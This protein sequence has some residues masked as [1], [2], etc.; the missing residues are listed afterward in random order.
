MRTLEKSMKKTCS[1]FLD[2]GR[3]WWCISIV[4]GEA[5][6]SCW[7][8]WGAEAGGCWHAAVLSGEV[9][10]WEE[11]GHADA[12]VSAQV[13]T[14]LSVQTGAAPCLLRIMWKYFLRAPG[15]GEPSL[16]ETSL[17]PGLHYPPVDRVD[18]SL[19]LISIRVLPP[20]LGSGEGEECREGSGEENGSLGGGSW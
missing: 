15:Q 3:W 18:I 5:G 13:S 19:P 8:W 4:L 12:G 6:G 2:P 7:H 17:L 11:R 10:R 1:F 9:E 16:L 14:A 20:T